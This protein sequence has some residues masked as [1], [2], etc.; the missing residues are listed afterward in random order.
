[1]KVKASGSITIKNLSEPFS[2]I[3]TNEAQQFSTDPNRKV[4]SAQSYYTD[5]IVYQGTTLRTDYTIGTINSANN[6][7]VS[8]NA[9]RVTFS[10]TAGVTVSSDAGSFTI[11]IIVDGKTV[12]KV[13]SWSCGKQGVTGSTGT[14]A[15]SVDITASSQVF[16]S[17][18]GG[19]TFSPN[20]IVLTPIFQG[21]ISFSKWQYSTNGGNNWTDVV[22]GNNGLYISS[23]VLTINKTSTLYTD[24]ITSITFKCISSNSA[25]YD[26]MT[27]M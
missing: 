25:Y 9:S 18:D 3:L 12:N 5:I 1:M 27:V 20:T 2:V 26:T 17:T 14:A 6:I 7:T 21:G 15:K 11:P 13:F 24:N 23:G 8:K 19:Q 16:K 4:T 10:V 22:S